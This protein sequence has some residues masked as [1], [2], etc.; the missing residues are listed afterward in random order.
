MTATVCGKTYSVRSKPLAVGNDVVLA[1][2][3]HQWVYLRLLNTKME[4]VIFD[5]NDNLR[6]ELRTTRHKSD[7]VFIHYFKASD[8]MVWHD[9]GYVYC[10]YIPA[11]TTPRL[12]H[13][14]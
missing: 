6:M 1:L 4:D 8:S 11:F 12:G 14:Q 10:P 2:S 3:G 7:L 5:G 9:T 13:S